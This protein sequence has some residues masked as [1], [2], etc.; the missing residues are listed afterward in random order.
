MK[1][2]TDIILDI[3][4][5]ELEAEYHHDNTSSIFLEL[6]KVVEAFILK[7]T[8]GFD[9]VVYTDILKDCIS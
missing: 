8:K 4:L 6:K 9:R 5:R 2:N 1:T 7:N 3:L